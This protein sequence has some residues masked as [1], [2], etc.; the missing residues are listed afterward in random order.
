MTDRIDLEKLRILYYPD[1]ILR[2][3]CRPVEDVDEGHQPLHGVGEA[4]LFPAGMLPGDAA[5]A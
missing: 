1:P 4:W 5:S 2:E 3:V